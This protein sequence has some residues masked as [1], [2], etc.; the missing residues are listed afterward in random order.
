M[1]L[2]KGMRDLKDLHDMSKEMPRASIGEGIAQAKDALQGVQDMQRVGATGVPGTARIVRVQDTGAA[3]NDHPLVELELELEVATA[4]HAP[5]TTVVRQ[6]VPR[7]QVGLLSPGAT[8]PV[9]IDPADATKVLIDWSAL[10]G[11]GAAIGAQAVAAP[12]R[13]RRC[14]RTR[15][16]ASSAC[17]RCATTACSPTPSSRRRNSG[18]SAPSERPVPVTH[19]RGGAG[20]W[21]CSRT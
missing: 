16:S 17:G 14:L 15:S 1:G 20:R 4:G 21:R 18:S 2:F 10:A 3:L 12:R 13:P 11:R 8:M 5:Y 19:P 9:K 7:L 6:A